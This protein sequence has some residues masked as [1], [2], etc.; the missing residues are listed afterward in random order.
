MDTFLS[1]G[2][3]GR[4]GFRECLFTTKFIFE[5]PLPDLDF[6]LHGVVFNIPYVHAYTRQQ[7]TL[8][9]PVPPSSIVL[10]P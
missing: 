6:T 7:R 8:A 10:T 1:P 3:S 9:L 4:P 5:Y 2:S